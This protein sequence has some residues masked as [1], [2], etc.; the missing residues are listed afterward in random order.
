MTKQKPITV[1]ADAYPMKVGTDSWLHLL[2][3]PEKLY[4]FLLISSLY[5]Q[6]EKQQK[7]NSGGCQVYGLIRDVCQEIRVKLTAAFFM[8]VRDARFSR[9]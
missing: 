9:L 5:L 7:D 3:Y 8:E 1:S 4:I 6:Q 2:Q